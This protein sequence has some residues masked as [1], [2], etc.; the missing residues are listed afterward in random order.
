MSSI[1]SSKSFPNILIY[2]MS[3]ACIDQFTRCAALELAS[4]NVRV[5]AVNPG[6][7]TGDIPKK[8]ADEGAYKEFLRYCEKM[9]S[10]GKSGLARDA[11][12]AIAFLASESASFITGA[13]LPIEGIGGPKSIKFA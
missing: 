4:K 7:I 1:A 13:C 9:N 12:S 8:K 6:I 5:N 2:S 3:K 11:A 10:L